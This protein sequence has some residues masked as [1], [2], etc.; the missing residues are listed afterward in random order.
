MPRT[1]SSPL[2]HTESR[3]SIAARE[4]GRKGGLATAKRATQQWLHERATKGGEATR[5]LYSV[6][7]YRHINQQRR[8]RN[9]WPQGKLRT[10]DQ[11]ATAEINSGGLA[12]EATFA[13]ANMISR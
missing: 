11:V 6:D 13:L 12:A 10:A 7:Y 9:G 8:V 3:R 1:E 2:E 4:N 5:D